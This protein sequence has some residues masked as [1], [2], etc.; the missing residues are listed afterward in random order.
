MR[1]I[2]MIFFSVAIAFLAI[3]ISGQRAFLYIGIA[4][5]V[6]AIARLV[7]VAKQ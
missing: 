2:S 4:F 3:G 6:L 1:T 5:M 7:R